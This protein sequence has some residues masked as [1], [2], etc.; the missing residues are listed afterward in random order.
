MLVDDILASGETLNALQESLATVGVKVDGVAI[1]GAAKSGNPSSESVAHQLARQL[2]AKLALPWTEI[3]QGLRLAHGN[4]YASLLRK[5]AQDAETKPNEVYDTIRRKGAALC[6]AA[7]LDVSGKPAHKPHAHPEGTGRPEGVGGVLRVA[8]S[9]LASARPAVS[10]K[11]RPLA[12]GEGRPPERSGTGARRNPAAISLEELAPFIDWTP[13]FH[14]W[15][16]R[17]VYPA[18]FQHEKHG[19]EARKLFA[20]A[21]EMLARVIREKL[22]TPRCVYGL[23]PANRVGDDVEIYTDESRQSIRTTFHFLRQQIEKTDGS[24]SWC[25]ADFI[26]PKGQPDHLGCFAVTAGAETK[27]LAD[28]YKAAN[29]D[30]NAIMI[31]AIADRLAEAFAEFMHKRVRNEWGFGKHENLSTEQLIEEAY[32]GIRPAPGYP[33]CPDHTE[34]G[35]LWSL[36]DVE[37][38]TGISLTESFAMWP[39]ASVSGFYFAHPESKYFA[40]GKID[41]DQVADLAR[42]K[43]RPLA[44]MERWL[45]PWLNYTAG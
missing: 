3:Y 15:E 23:F 28:A 38:N 14:T 34:K 17:G 26:A 21:Q 36:L 37:K 43:G 42:R 27:A 1:L 30:Y 10:Q 19:E 9:E 24:P 12:G 39:G 18:I 31:E 7:R 25:L 32:R 13:F 22:L 45:G 33:A 5:A 44:E 41:R 20:D 4:A 6:E 16:L 40:V 29:D 35:P 2:A 8:A 11:V